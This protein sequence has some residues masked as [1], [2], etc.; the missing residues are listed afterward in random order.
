MRYNVIMKTATNIKIFLI[1]ALMALGAVFIVQN[2]E[3]VEI[4]FFFW[5]LSVSRVLLLIS[6][7]AVGFIIGVLTTIVIVRKNTSRD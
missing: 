1:L 4:R 5:K 3:I 6:T 2:T 7:T